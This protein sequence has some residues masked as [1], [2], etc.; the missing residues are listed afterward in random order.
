[1]KFGAQLSL[2]TLARE[3][4]NPIYL[5]KV[6]T[7]VAGETSQDVSARPRGRHSKLHHNTAHEQ[8]VNVLHTTPNGAN[9]HEHI[10]DMGQR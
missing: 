3:Y 5:T 7:C 10:P 6:M 2:Q 4:P 1:M 9:N 8:G